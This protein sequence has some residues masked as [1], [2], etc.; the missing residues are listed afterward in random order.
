MP[1]PAIDV[2]SAQLPEA[3]EHTAADGATTTTAFFFDIFDAP[4]S[5]ALAG[6]WATPQFQVAH[7]GAPADGPSHEP[8]VHVAVD[9][10]Q[11]QSTA[12][13]QSSHPVYCE[14]LP[15]VFV[16]SNCQVVGQVPARGP[17][18]VPALHVRVC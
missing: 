8:C 11:P 6:H 4:A 5:W 7:A 10:H 14:Q 1:H 17:A 12:L 16:A 18:A 15:H 3:A 2:Q 9:P 13:T